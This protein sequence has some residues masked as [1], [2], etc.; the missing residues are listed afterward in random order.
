MP[1][2]HPELAP[3]S[4]L[5]DRLTAV[6]RRLPTPGGLSPVTAGALNTLSRYGA[7][8]LS[9]L[10]HSEA[11]TQPGMTQLVARL[12]RDGLA[13]RRPDPQ[14]RR[15]VLV[16]ITPAGQALLAERRAARAGQIAEFVSALDGGA[17]GRLAAAIPALEQIAELGELARS[18]RLQPVG[19]GA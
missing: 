13:Q 16:A 9:D 14:D 11:V 12:E 4:G 10:A 5:L 3:L 17:Q 7:T 1:D 6:I 18:A 2:L 8:R 19:V 15:A